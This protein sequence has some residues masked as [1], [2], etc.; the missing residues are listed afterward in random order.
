MVQYTVTEQQYTCCP[1]GNN[2]YK[3]YLRLNS[4]TQQYDQASQ[5]FQYNAESPEIEGTEE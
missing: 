5:G 2:G 1:I 4:F 3:K